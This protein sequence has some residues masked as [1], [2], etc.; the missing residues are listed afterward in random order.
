MHPS[1]RVHLEPGCVL[2]RTEEQAVAS[3]RTCNAGPVTS[4]QLTEPARASE[5]A[6]ETEDFGVVMPALNRKSDRRRLSCW[7]WIERSRRA[8]SCST[9]LPRAVLSATVVWAFSAS[10]E[11]PDEPA[12]DAI[13]Q[14][15]RRLYENPPAPAASAPAASAPTPE[16]AESLASRVRTARQ[17]A[18]EQRRA[19]EVSLPSTEGLSQTQLEIRAGEQNLSIYDAQLFRG[20]GTP[21]IESFRRLTIVKLAEARRKELFRVWG[22]GIYH[23]EA[24]DVLSDYGRSMAELR[25][26][27]FLAKARGFSGVAQR[28]DELMQQASLAFERDMRRL[29]DEVRDNPS[30]ANLSRE[31]H[32]PAAP[33]RR[34]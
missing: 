28:S 26:I 3:S 7:L 9:L 8:L 25:R 6:A 23:P 10:A 1:V 11:P 17:L 22:N 4:P 14:Q 15:E 27:R 2:V 12:N 33:T 24:F 34:R 20:E 21:S 5:C 30:F 19:V 16:S 18:A 31:L 13:F 32:E 29:S